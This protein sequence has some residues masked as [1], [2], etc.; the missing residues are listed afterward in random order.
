MAPGKLDP[1]VALE[2]MRE[3]GLEPLTEYPGAGKPWKAKCLKCGTVGSPTLAHVQSRGEVA[4][5]VG[6]LEQPMQRG[7]TLKPPQ[8]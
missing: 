1:I 7:S 5:N 2:R 4:K 3:F 6:E 8:S